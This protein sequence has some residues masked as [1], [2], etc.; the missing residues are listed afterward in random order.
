M[1]ASAACPRTQPRG[2]DLLG[3]TIREGTHPVDQGN[4]QAVLQVKEGWKVSHH[5]RWAP[6]TC[7]L[8]WYSLH[9]YQVDPVLSAKSMFLGVNR[10][11]TSV[12]SYEERL[13]AMGVT[14]LSFSALIYERGI[15]VMYCG[16]LFRG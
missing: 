2:S 7:P 8:S 14:S 1:P 10:P 5:L 16:R 12:P 3:G 11:G 13:W 15:N 9:L 4:C 6:G